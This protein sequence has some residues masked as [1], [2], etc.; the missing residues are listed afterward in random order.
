M[1][2]RASELAPKEGCPKGKCCAF[3]SALGTS[4]VLVVE[5]NHYGGELLLLQ[6]VMKNEI[7]LLSNNV[8][9][10]DTPVFVTYILL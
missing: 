4:E 9:I 7:S 2:A 8:Y 1:E 5:D 3:P 6:K 10:D